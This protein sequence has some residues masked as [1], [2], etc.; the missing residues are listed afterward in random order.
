MKHKS[1]LDRL[2]KRLPADEDD[3]IVIIRLTWGGEDDP[4]KPPIVCRRTPGGKLIK[5]GHDTIPRHLQGEP[6]KINTVWD[7][8]I[9]EGKNETT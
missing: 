6:V 3:T 4:E 2:S 9:I 7:D 1:R 5:I 8:P